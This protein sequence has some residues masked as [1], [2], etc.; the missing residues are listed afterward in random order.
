MP[1]L[2]ISGPP[3]W[4][5]ESQVF[6]DAKHSPVPITRNDVKRFIQVI[7]LKPP[8]QNADPD[9]RIEYTWRGEWLANFPL[10]TALDTSDL[11]AWKSWIKNPSQL[12]FLDETIEKCYRL[13]DDSRH[14]SGWAF[15]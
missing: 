4:E 1:D 10:F 8:V 3:P 5:S 9:G 14:A 13:A 6:S 7:E 11:A 2:E 15:F 12:R